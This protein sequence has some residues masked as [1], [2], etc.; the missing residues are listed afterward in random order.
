[1]TPDRKFFIALGTILF[2]AVV[3]WAVLMYMELMQ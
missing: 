2:V 1:M 3:P